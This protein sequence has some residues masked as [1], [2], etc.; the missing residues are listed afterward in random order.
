MARYNYTV[1][2][3]RFK[4][5]LANIKNFSKCMALAIRTSLFAVSVLVLLFLGI[6]TSLACVICIPYPK[7]TLADDLIA[8]H[9]IA[10][11]REDPNKPY[12]LAIL[13]TLKGTT[14]DFSTSLFLPSFEQRKL[15][16]NPEDHI[17]LIKHQASSK[18]QWLSY[19]TPGSL[20]FILEVLSHERKWRGNRGK[21]MRFRYFLKRL[22][23]GNRIIREEAFLEI[24]RA[25]YSWIKMAAR[26]V[27]IESVRNT[28]AN[29]S[30][31]EFH[32][33]YIL[34]L[35]QS[36]DDKDKAYI[37]KSF[38]SAAR[39]GFIRNLSAWTTAFVETHPI[40]SIEMIEKLY[41]QSRTRSRKELE[42][43]LKAISVLTTVEHPLLAHRKA[44]LRRDVLDAY[45]SLLDNHPTLAG[46]VARDLTHWRKKALVAR[47]I[48]IRRNNKMLDPASVFAVDLY[49]RQLSDYAK[50]STSK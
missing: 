5:I 22:N 15:K 45:A 19:V 21:M 25:P 14:D 31:I 26:R 37:R 24:G 29:W 39:F 4:E 11:A 49:L 33:L 42:E 16:Q 35:A 34:M 50:L 18:W 46:W 9:V 3:G 36:N 23:D 40:E 10:L 7:S 13:E 38:E 44:A 20:E 8:S 47:F 12:S 30:L 27:P 43:V 2:V 48:E 32:S 6:T 41:F 28:L 1:S 17:V